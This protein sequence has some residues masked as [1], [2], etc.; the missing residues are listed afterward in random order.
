[1]EIT[2]IFKQNFEY[3]FS[4]Q[5]ISLCYCSVA[6]FMVALFAIEFIMKGI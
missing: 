5:M 3:Q 2:H 6:F 4:A 1:M